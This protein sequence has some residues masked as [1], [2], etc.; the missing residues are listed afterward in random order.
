MPNQLGKIYVC[1]ACGAQVIVT[2]GGSGAL[3]CCGQAMEQ[4]K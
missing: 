3:S 4:K 1:G 2:K